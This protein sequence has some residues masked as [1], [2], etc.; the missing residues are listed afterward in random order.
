[1]WYS[2]CLMDSPVEGLWNTCGSVDV[3]EPANVGCGVLEARIGDALR[4]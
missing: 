1:M 4:P 3:S 2:G